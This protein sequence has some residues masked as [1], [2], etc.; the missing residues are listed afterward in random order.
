[1]GENLMVCCWFMPGDTGQRS[2]GEMKWKQYVE[3][4]C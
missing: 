2:L 1:M 3:G 4:F